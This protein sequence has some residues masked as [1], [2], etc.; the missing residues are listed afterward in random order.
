MW[1]WGL[2]ACQG[3]GG[4]SAG[5]SHM[6]LMQIIGTGRPAVRPCQLHDRHYDRPQLS[7]LCWQMS[8]NLAG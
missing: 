6:K 2:R 5:C 7:V 1:R 8:G 3:Q 4:S